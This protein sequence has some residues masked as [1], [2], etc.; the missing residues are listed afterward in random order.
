MNKVLLLGTVDKEPDV[1]YVDKGIC[2]A[3]LTLRTTEKKL[4]QGNAEQNDITEYHRVVL[5][6]ELGEIVEKEVHS[7]DTIYVEGTLHYRSYTDRSGQSHHIVE[8]WA[9]SLE[10][11]H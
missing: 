1:R 9:N 7:D 5:W 8:V 10:L 4:S 11:I 3:Q 2:V 6:R